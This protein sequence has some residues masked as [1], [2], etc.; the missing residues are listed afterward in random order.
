MSND[1][2][3]VRLSWTRQRGGVARW[4]DVCIALPAEVQPA[5]QFSTPLELDML[6]FLPTLPLYE[7]R[8]R[9]GAAR[10][11]ELDERQACLQFLRQLCDPFDIFPRGMPF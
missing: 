7:L 11:M 2:Y 1:L 10:G 5:V 3:L 4:Y 6:E 8:P 9:D